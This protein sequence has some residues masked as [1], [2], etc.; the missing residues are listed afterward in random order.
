MSGSR[1]TTPDATAPDNWLSRFVQRPV[2]VLMLA[3]TLLLVGAIAMLK[4][5]IRLP[6]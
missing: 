3:V 6:R 2:T 4:L 5:P 1:A